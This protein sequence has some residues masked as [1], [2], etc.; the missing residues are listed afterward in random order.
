MLKEISRIT[1]QI[2]T[3]ILNNKSVLLYGYF[4][5]LNFPVLILCY[6][7]VWFNINSVESG[8]LVYNTYGV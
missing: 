4:Y 3:D 2:K 1:N 6:R 8:V 5:Y 7:N